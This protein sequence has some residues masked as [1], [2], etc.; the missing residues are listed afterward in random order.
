MRVL[1]LSGTSKAANIMF[2]LGLRKRL[3]GTGVLT[4]AGHPGIID[5]EL[6][7]LHVFRPVMVSKQ[8]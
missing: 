6:G 4:T 3:S 2:T 7:R 1:L 5:T 8:Y